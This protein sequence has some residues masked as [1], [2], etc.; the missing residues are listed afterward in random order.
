M[1]KTS[2][3]FPRKRGNSFCVKLRDGLFAVGVLHTTG[4]TTFAD[5]F[6]ESPHDSVPSDVF[7]DP[8]FTVDVQMSFF[9][10]SEIYKIDTVSE[11]FL[12]SIPL[13]SHVIR[14]RSRPFDP[15]NPFGWDGLFPDEGGGL[16]ELADRM[17]PSTSSNGR[18]VVDLLDPVTDVELIRSTEIS[19][20]WINWDLKE[21]LAACHAYGGNIDPYKARVFE[22]CA[23][24][25]NEVVRNTHWYIKHKMPLL[26]RQFD[27]ES[28][29]W[30]LD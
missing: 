8:L 16:I 6:L 7:T 25:Q 9:G 4:L 2:K 18:V 23:P 14:V 24:L 22:T 19:V 21:R 3:R 13:S 15:K 26:G 5:C 11:D 30:I 1:R 12:T 20:L 28:N 29:A 17:H 27:P 10:R